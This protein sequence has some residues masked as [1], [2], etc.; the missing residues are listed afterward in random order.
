MRQHFGAI[1]AQ[2]ET[3]EL[4]GS[5]F[6]GYATQIAEGAEQVDPIAGN[7][8]S[9]TRGIAVIEL[10]LSRIGDLP[11]LDARFGVEGNE[12]VEAVGGI[13]ASGDGES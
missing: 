2:L 10:S 13:P 6:A 5:R 1:V 9:R 8:R 11:A 4:G 12:H 7:D 3:T